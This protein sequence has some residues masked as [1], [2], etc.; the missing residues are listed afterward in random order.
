MRDIQSLCQNAKSLFHFLLSNISSHT[1]RLQIH[2]KQLFSFFVQLTFTL[3]FVC[4]V[5]VFSLLTTLFLF[6]LSIMFFFF[7]VKACQK[8]NMSC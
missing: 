3:L 5:V 8:Q 7:H 4:F 1:E 2:N 6:D